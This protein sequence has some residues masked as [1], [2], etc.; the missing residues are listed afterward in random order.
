MEDP[1]RRKSKLVLREKRILQLVSLAMVRTLRPRR[2]HTLL[3]RVLVWMEQAPRRLSP[4]LLLRRAP[5]L[6]P[7]AREQERRLVRIKEP[8]TREYYFE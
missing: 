5:N 7:L 8:I 3:Q 2:K 1:L 4:A 6:P